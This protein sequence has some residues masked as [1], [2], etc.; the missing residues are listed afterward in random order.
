MAKRILVVDDEPDIR[1]LVAEALGVTGYDVQTAANGGE[2]VRAA[3]LYL[4]DLVLLDIMMPVLNGYHVCRI[5]KADKE[6]AAIPV[7]MLT[8]RTQE[9]D[10]AVAKESGADD[11]VTKPFAM[12]DLLAVVARR[13]GRPA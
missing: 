7:V 6:L 13:L 1:R 5:L 12:P 2:A 11:Y 9:R 4:P 8:A 3:S 10:Y